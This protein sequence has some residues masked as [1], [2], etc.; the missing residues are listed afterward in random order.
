VLWQQ[1]FEETQ[2]RPEKAAEQIKTSLEKAGKLSERSAIPPEKWNLEAFLLENT[3]GGNKNFVDAAVELL[4][5]AGMEARS[6]HGLRYSPGEKGGFKFK[7]WILLSEAHMS[8]WA[9]WKVPGGMWQP[10]VIH[11]ETVLDNKPPPPPEED[12]ENLLARETVKAK[13]ARKAAPDS[14]HVAAWG[15]SLVLLFAVFLGLWIGALHYELRVATEHEALAFKW[16]LGLL[17]GLGH[18]CPTGEGWAAF[19]RRVGRVLPGAAVELCWVRRALENRRWKL[20]NDRPSVFLLQACLLR[21]V[22]RLLVG[23]PRAKAAMQAFSNPS[24]TNA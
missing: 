19:E 9:E 16:M 4:R 13:P 10:L 5:M 21:F 22:W 1:I 6:V 3:T 18:R 11:P 17:A 7:E 2:I 23:G 20:K 24:Q 15:R 14:N 12:L 8:D